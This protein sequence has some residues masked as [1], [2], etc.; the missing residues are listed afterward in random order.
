L[1][2]DGFD[3]YKA[4]KSTTQSIGGIFGL[5]SVVSA[6][7]PDIDRSLRNAKKKG[8]KRHMDSSSDELR[9]RL[10]NIQ[11]YIKAIYLPKIEAIN[12]ESSD[13]FESLFQDLKVKNDALTYY[14]EH[15]HLLVDF[16][17]EL[18]RTR[19]LA[20]LIAHSVDLFRD[21]EK[22][23]IT[24]TRERAKITPEL[25]SLNELLRNLQKVRTLSN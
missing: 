24:L 14:T 22:E 9:S 20:R 3:A 11:K 6:L 15:N 8:I 21:T 17:Q 1:I 18:H 25:V 4:L 12:D 2:P 7:L 19:Q 23:I 16:Y 5:G 13:Q 10:L